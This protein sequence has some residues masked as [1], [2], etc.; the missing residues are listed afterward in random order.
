MLDIRPI[1]YYLSYLPG[2]K[3]SSFGAWLNPMLCWGG[4]LAIFAMI[5]LALF[6][7]DRRAGFILVGYLAQLVPWMFI[8]RTTFEYHYFACT[9]F[10][11]LSLCRVFSLMRGNSQH[12][13][14]PVYGFTGASAALFA[15]FYPVLSGLTVSQTYAD[16]FLRWLPTWPF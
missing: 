2:D 6:R 7:R 12:W 1:L 16:G 14:L 3:V 11:T 8:S 15:V 13:K 4:L 10:L 5:Y 9:V